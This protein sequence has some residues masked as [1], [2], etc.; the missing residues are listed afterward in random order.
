VAY[1]DAL[2]IK[3]RDKSGV[4]NKSVYIVFGVRPDGS[5]DVLGLWNQATEG[6]KFRLTILSE[7]RQRGDAL[8]SIP[9]EPAQQ[10]ADVHGRPGPVHGFRAVHLASRLVGTE[11]LVRIDQAPVPGWQ[12]VGQSGA[13]SIFSDSDPKAPPSGTIR[14]NSHSPMP[15]ETNSVEDVDEADDERRAVDTLAPSAQASATARTRGSSAA[16]ARGRRRQVAECSRMGES[17]TLR[18]K[19]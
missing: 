17:P 13:P 18:T 6:A 15:P 2:V 12:G 1:L 5:K 3:V 4:Q 9:S 11:S 7:L 16:R 14:S 19:G 10:E 8:L